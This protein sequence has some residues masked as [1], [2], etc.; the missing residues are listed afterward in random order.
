[1][2]LQVSPPHPSSARDKRTLHE[3]L[4]ALPPQ[5]HSQTLCVQSLEWAGGTGEGQLHVTFFQMLLHLSQGHWLAALLAWNR[6]VAAGPHVCLL[7][8]T[9]VRTLARKVASQLDVGTGVG[10]LRQISVAQHLLASHTGAISSGTPH[11][12][13]AEQL[14]IFRS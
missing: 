5:V 4:G 14:L 11:A 13:V 6:S 2:F 8:L 9:Q 10:V 1:M 12:D 3:A 7:L